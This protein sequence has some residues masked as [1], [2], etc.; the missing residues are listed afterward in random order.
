MSLFEPDDQVRKVKKQPVK[1][2]AK[3]K[4]AKK[5][6]TLGD[7]IASKTESKKI[8]VDGPVAVGGSVSFEEMDAPPTAKA[9]AKKAD[10]GR[11]EP[12][13]NYVTD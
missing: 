12:Q 9:A 1:K 4:A 7:Q 13:I 5:K 10:S 2:V 6:R 8:L 11:I 3:K